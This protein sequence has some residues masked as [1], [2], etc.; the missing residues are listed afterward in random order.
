MRPVSSAKSL[1]ISERWRLRLR[2][3][4]VLVTL[5][6]ILYYMAFPFVAV[7][8]HGFVAV[9]QPDNVLS[10]AELLPDRHATEVLQLGDVITAIDDVP[11][12]Q[13]IRQPLFTPGQPVYTYTIQRSGEELTF[14]IPVEE[15]TPE[16]VLQVITYRMT[17][18]LVGLIFW[19]VGALVVLYATPQNRDAWLLG[20]ITLAVATVLAASEA[21]L[22]NA[23]GA[24]LLSNPFYPILAV[25][26]VHLALIPR[27]EKGSANARRLLTILYSLAA[28]LGLIALFELLTLAQITK[29]WPDR[30]HGNETGS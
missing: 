18:G 11:A 26:L 29:L 24:W 17:T 16:S 3:P 20:G 12:R 19:L 1:H 15:R 14:T 23:P 21:A 6:L 2:L 10:V 25:A 9:W 4:L 28:G 7:P 13:H 22:Y 30:P 8:F 5:V 27:P